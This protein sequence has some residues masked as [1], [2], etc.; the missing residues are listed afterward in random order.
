[1]KTKILIADDHQLFA[2]GIINI[3]QQ[4]KQLEM[5]GIVGDGLALLKKLAT[6]QVD[7]VLL[8]VSMPHMDGIEAAK[9]I[10]ADYPGTKILMV[11]MND[12]PE[13]LKALIRTGVHGIILKNTGKTELLL[14]VEEL[15][16]G[17]T[18]FSQKITKQLASEYSQP[19]GEH[20]QLT[21]REK[22]VLQ[23]VYEGLST[24]QIAEKLFIST[25]TVETHRKNLFVKSGLNKSSQL[26]K[27][28]QE[29]GYLK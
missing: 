6:E 24:A 21:K 23:L 29:L 25:Y 15:M 10:R 13:T 8:D 2:E 22:E 11:T 9:R 5:A 20:W 19:A 4:E 12:Q 28:A 26:V 7:L 1:M 16:L 17:N 3:L 18:Y 27:R 14:A